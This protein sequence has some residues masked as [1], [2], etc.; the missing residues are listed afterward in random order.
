M[1]RKKTIRKLIPRRRPDSHKGDFGRI[2]IVAGSVGMSGA[3]IMA[4][5]AALRSG[6][7]LVTVGVPESLS[8]VMAKRLTESM[9]KVLPETKSGTL[10]RRAYPKIQSFV[11]SQNVLA[12]GPGLS[13]NPETQK[14]IQK[15]VLASRI[16]VVLDADGLNAFAG[17]A[18]QLRKIKAPL[19]ATPHPGEFRR[20]FKEV[21]PG[22]SRGRIKVARKIA[23]M[24]RIYLILKGHQTVVADPGGRTFIN[25]T[26]NAG[27]A[28]GG[29]G[30]VLT[31]VMAALLGQKLKPFDAACAAV[32][33]HGLAGDLAA[34][35]I[36]QI[37]MIA[38]DII[39][40]LPQA[41]RRLT[42]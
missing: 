32:Y 42:K 7:G 35:K 23:K 37:S 3:A 41:F 12:I 34:K 20:L 27:M 5:Q 24:Y 4:S 16:P 14:L 29:S 11:K 9:F 39:Q 22:D 13:Q 28:T 31:G 38:S 36:G 25:S 1:S 21:V 17:K 2:F 19:I 15:V 10:S 30:D 40:F 18:A 33:C 6:A 8:N 26:G